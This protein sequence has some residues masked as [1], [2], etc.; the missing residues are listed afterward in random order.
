[1]DFI[2]QMPVKIYFGAECI[3]D[4]Q[5]EFSQWG[6]R[7]LIVTGKNSAR[8]SGALDDVRKALASQGIEYFLFD[9]VEENPT[10]ATVEK[11]SHLARKDNIEMIIGI[12]GGSA[13]DAAKAIAAL[14]PNNITGEQ[15]FSGLLPV[16]PLPILAVPLTAGTGSEVTQHAVMVDESRHSKRSFSYPE[17]FPKA[18]FLDAKYGLSLPWHV[19]IHTA[20]DALS[21]SIEGYASKKATP[22]TDSIALTSIRVFG[23]A[24]PALKSRSLQLVD[25][26]RLLYTSML[27]G[28]VIAQ[29][30]TTL[31]H[32]L[33]YPLTYSRNIPHGR[34]HGMLLGEYLRFIQPAAYEKVNQILTAMQLKTVDEFK[35]LMKTLLDI[36]ETFTVEEIAEY[37]QVAIQA[38][39]MANTARQPNLD[40][41]KQIL[42][43][44]IG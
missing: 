2:Y 26:E 39:N 5:K 36:T 10:V 29:T 32:G 6:R 24:I 28:F 19:T 25:R 30:G 23:D 4:Q 7:A 42:A 35:D 8:L 14:V 20:V 31:A 1:M 33:G 27:A 41:L 13:L 18:A 40:D 17:L 22:I 11:G 12:G 21:H 38:K 44:S 16:K 9:Q 15:L 43:N 3:R 34:A 37:S